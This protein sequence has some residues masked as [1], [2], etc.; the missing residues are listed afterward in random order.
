MFSKKS[1]AKLFCVGAGKTGTTSV[2]KALS[3]F[4]Y[5][6]GDQVKAELLLDDYS[7]RNFKAIIEYCK[8][9]DAF[10]DAPFCFQHTY[11][12][13]DQSFPN[14][15]FILTVRDSDEQ[16]Y[17]S[18]VNFHRKNYASGNENPT[19]ND[20]KNAT[21]RYKG[22]A[23]EVRKKVF[24]ILEDEDPY[25]EVKLKQYYN[26]HNNSIIDYFKNKPNLL[27]INVAKKESYKKLCGFLNR[28]PL[29][30]EFPWENETAKI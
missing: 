23:A 13:L 20:L 2:E 25:S 11:Q 10:Q 19:W 6:M 4:G 16:W 21:Y 8:T 17:N 29:Y 30:D 15:K 27:I 3:D 24:G 26:T 5:R 1:K 28:K 22:Y 18:L 7:K 9:A 12:A 14:S